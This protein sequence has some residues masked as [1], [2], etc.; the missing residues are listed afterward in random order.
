[1]AR[2]EAQKRADKKYQESDKYHYKTISTKLHTDKIE[3]I[4]EAANKAGVS[5]SKFLVLAAEYCIDNNIKFE[6]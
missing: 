5:T 1:M 2:S 4:S 3:K 6:D